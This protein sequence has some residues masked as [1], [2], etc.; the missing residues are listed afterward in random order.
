MGQ[1]RADGRAGHNKINV[2]CCPLN[3]SLCNSLTL[4]LMRSPFPNK[5]DGQCPCHTISCSTK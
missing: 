2:P 5:M 4:S 3:H 1:D